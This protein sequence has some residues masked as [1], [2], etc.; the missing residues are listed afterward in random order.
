MLFRKSLNNEGFRVERLTKQE[1][2]QALLAIMVNFQKYCEVNQLQFYLCAG[3]L[4]GA[5]RHHG[6]IPW[7]DDVDVCMGRPQYDRLLSLAKK[8]P[9]FGGH[10]KMIVFDN[11][12][13]HY[14]YIKILDTLVETDQKYTNEKGEN[15]LWIDVFPFDGV[16]EDFNQR[17]KLFKKTIRARK[18]IL[19]AT[20]KLFQA[21]GGVLKHIYKPFLILVA[22]IYGVKR[23]NRCIIKACH[24]TNYASANLVGDVAWGDPDSEIMKK[25][26]FEKSAEVHFEN[27]TF[28]TMSCWHQYLIETY[29]E[30]YNQLPSKD[31]RV[32]HDLIA[33]RVN[34]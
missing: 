10:Y 7:D 30:N 20:A 6:F 32:T 17:Q 3:T 25:A 2:K 18:I 4:L 28:L 14:P 11:G 15:N 23:A 22:R 31:Q 5:I 21:K 24:S 13:S 9:Q 16:D 19:L 34:E 29:G 8:E 12:T 33:W 1:V 26:D 27:H